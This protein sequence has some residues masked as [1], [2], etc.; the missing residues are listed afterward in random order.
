VEADPDRVAGD[1]APGRRKLDGSLVAMNTGLDENAAQ[2]ESAAEDL[3]GSRMNGHMQIDTEQ[4]PRAGPRGEVLAGGP[5]A[6]SRT[7]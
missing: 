1:H 6:G 4:E 7:A 2:L 5:A 3:P